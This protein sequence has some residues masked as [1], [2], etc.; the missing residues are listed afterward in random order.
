MHMKQYA[1][2]LAGIMVVGTAFAQHID[3][4]ESTLVARAGFDAAWTRTMPESGEEGWTA[5]DPTRGE[6]VL[7]TRRWGLPGIPPYGRFSMLLRPAR[8]FTVLMPFQDDAVFNGLRDPALF[9]AHVGQEWAVYLNGSLLRDEFVRS[10]S[11]YLERSLRDVIVPLDRRL[12]V[13]GQN[14][15]AF[16][17][18]GD[19]SDDRTGFNMVGPYTIDSYAALV[20]RNHEYL[21]LMLIGIY[22]FF[23][24]YH[25]L[26]FALR[27]REAS[28]LYFGVSTLLLASYIAMR[29]TVAPSI[30]AD[31]SILRRIEYVSL[32]MA[33][34]AVMAFLESVLH[35]RV[36]PFTF[37]TAAVT[38]AMSIAGQILRLEPFLYVWYFVALAAVIHYLIFTLGVALVRDFKL[39]SSGRKPGI[40]GLA[41]TMGTL[42]IKRDPGALAIG[43]GVL[44]FAV[45]L[46]SMAAS[47][48]GNVSWSKFAF[49]LFI[50]TTA[51]V[52]ARGF[53]EVAA[54]A[55]AQNDDLEREV[56]TR[57]SALKTA[58]TERVMRAASSS[59]Q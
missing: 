37:V 19:P 15:I 11:G 24:L 46:D 4:W 52:L 29:T 17:L 9:L 35:G 13:P 25:F 26:L 8:D 28:N 14:L 12:L 7:E 31:T 56:E 38:A 45:L 5:L 20:G 42:A 48:G 50:L 16:H 6:R 22:T 39:V 43:S 23:G 44:I 36:L 2:L 40:A 33:L 3:L 30:I 58:A 34:P 55:E 41:G 47:T 49:L 54:R 59:S 57:T 21:D 18:R 1:A 10:G 51:S 27:P 53:A 32:F